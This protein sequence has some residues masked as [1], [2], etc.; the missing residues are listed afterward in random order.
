M[1]DQGHQGL[2]AVFAGANLAQV[3]EDDH[4]G[5]GVVGRLPLAAVGPVERRDPYGPSPQTSAWGLGT[6]A[7]ANGRT[8]PRG[9][10]SSP[11]HTGAPCSGSTRARP[12][13]SGF[14]E[15]ARRPLSSTPVRFA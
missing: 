9:S 3:V 15:W 1:L 5:L 14:R 12:R 7:P 11:G 8:R 10:R 13:K 2:V 4:L 6:S